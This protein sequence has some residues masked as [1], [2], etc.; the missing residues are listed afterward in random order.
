MNE[1]RFIELLNVYVDQ[2]LSP[3]EAAELEA[4]IAR[5]P[6]RHRT[7]QQ[8]CRMQ[9][10][11]S[12]LFEYERSAA[13][14][15]SVLTRALATADRKIETP[16]T[17]V[18]RSTWNW[19]YSFAAVAAAACVAVVVVLQTRPGGS[20]GSPAPVYAAAEQE[21]AAPAPVAVAAATPAVEEFTAVFSTQPAKSSVRPGLFM[22][23]IRL[24]DTTALE[25]TRELTFAP[26]RT[27]EGAQLTFDTKKAAEETTLSDFR[28]A[29]ETEE[30]IAA[31]QF[32]K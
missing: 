7:Y 31:F 11:C 15:S 17:G 2:Q 10:A 30:P 28:P 16:V 18:S 19:G 21:P 29:Q 25:W 1:H 26:V 27:V 5:S 14:A 9:K 13:P 4:E 12:Q 32:Q 3:E 8:Y 24:E 6:A 23:G 22:S 20:P